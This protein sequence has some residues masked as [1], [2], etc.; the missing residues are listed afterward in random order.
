MDSQ[1]LTRNEI[2]PRLVA[3][4]AKAGRRATPEDSKFRSPEIERLRQEI[5]E[6]F[7]R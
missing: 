5:E 3:R 7:P 1:P 4:W 2:D 6:R